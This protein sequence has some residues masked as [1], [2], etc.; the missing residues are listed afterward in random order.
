MPVTAH[1]I[2]FTF[3]GRELRETFE[4]RRQSGA[5]TERDD[6]MRTRRRPRLHRVQVGDCYRSG[7]M[8]S[9]VWTAARPGTPSLPDESG[10]STCRGEKLAAR[11][12]A[13]ASVAE[14]LTN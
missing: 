1:R 4:N 2:P 13:T 5:A 3:L 8:G 6:A 7:A 11:A 14:L 12:N 9:V 10:N